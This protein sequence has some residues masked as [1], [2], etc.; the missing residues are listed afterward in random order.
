MGAPRLWRAPSR[1][2]REPRDDRPR[3]PTPPALRATRPVRPVAAALLTGEDYAQLRPASGSMGLML[4]SASERLC[5]RGG[6]HFGSPD[7]QPAVRLASI[8]AAGEAAVPFTSGLL[9]GIGE[10]RAERLHALFALRDLHR[11]HGHLQEAIIQ[12]FRAKAGTRM[13]E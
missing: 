9:I 6:P 5:Q 1:S 8:A 7:K 11:A 13:A 2:A 4:E 12:N 10:T 3:P